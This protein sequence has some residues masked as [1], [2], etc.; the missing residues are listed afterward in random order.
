M[1]ELTTDQAIS[2]TSK[3][4]VNASCVDVLEMGDLTGLGIQSVLRKNSDPA[5]DMAVFADRSTMP[6]AEVDRLIPCFTPGT[7]IAT[8]RGAVLVETLQVGDRVIT[9]DNG[10]QRIEWVGKKRLDHMQLKRLKGLRPV[11][12]DAGALGKNVPDRNM[13]VSPAHRML[14]VSKVAQLYFGQSE[15][16]VAAKDMCE[17]PGVRVAETPYVTYVHFLCENH[18]LVLADGAW[19]E[20]FQ[21]NDFSLKGLD[22]EQREKLFNFFPELATKEG[23]KGYRAARPSLSKQKAA[24]IFKKK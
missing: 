11:Q 20:S 13:L 1:S 2:D 23:L 16:L 21:P 15:V 22:D 17:M 14:V 12:I 5:T 9:R 19:S 7:Y 18:E 10:I 3:S 4:D 24:L 8:P 6:L